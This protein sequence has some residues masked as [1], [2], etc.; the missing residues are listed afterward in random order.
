MANEGLFGIFKGLTPKLIQTTL[1][2][3][4]ILMIY[5]RVKVILNKKLQWSFANLLVIISFNIY[6]LFSFITKLVQNEVIFHFTWA[7][8]NLESI[9]KD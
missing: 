7:N 5:E 8:W 6:R 1:N 9:S 4:L 2:S 3:A